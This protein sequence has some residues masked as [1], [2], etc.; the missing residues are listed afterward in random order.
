MI[1]CHA[2]IHRYIQGLL[3]D[4]SYLLIISLIICKRYLSPI[5]I[6]KAEDFPV[7]SFSENDLNHPGKSFLSL[8][9]SISA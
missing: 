6:V 9:K 1:N 5:N 8:S 7:F 3:R 4:L 2:Y